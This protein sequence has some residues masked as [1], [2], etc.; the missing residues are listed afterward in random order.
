MAA[1]FLQE[2]VTEISK[3]YWPSDDTL[4]TPQQTSYTLRHKK[5]KKKDQ[6]IS[7]AWSNA[8]HV[9]ITSSYKNKSV[10]LT[11]DIDVWSVQLLPILMSSDLLRNNKD[12]DGS[13]LVADKNRLR[14]YDFT[15]Q[16]K[17]SVKFNGSMHECLK[18]KINKRNSNR[19][20]YAWLSIDHYYLPLRMEQYKDNEL[21]ASM[22]LEEFKLLK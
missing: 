3:L 13:I 16:G 4:E 15:L 7:F 5:K 22:T 8:K 17:K 19:F 14:N 20:T 10:V 1:F 18:F 6:A 2:E 12:T 21:S 9:E 11:S